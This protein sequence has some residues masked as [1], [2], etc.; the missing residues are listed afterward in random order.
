MMEKY[1]ETTFEE[2]KRIE[3]LYILENGLNR[4]PSSK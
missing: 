4:E 2:F 3:N 1:L